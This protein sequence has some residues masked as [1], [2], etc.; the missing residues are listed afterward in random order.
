MYNVFFNIN[1]C[2]LEALVPFLDGGFIIRRVGF[3]EIHI[4]LR[5]LVLTHKTTHFNSVNNKTVRYK[6]K[7]S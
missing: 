2:Y 6:Q 4:L 3:E 1:K 7:F 5:Q